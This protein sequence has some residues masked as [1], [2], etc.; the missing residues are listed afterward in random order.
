MLLVLVACSPFNADFDRAQPEDLSGL[1]LLYGLNGQM[2]PAFLAFAGRLYGEEEGCPQVTVR[3]DGFDLF[4]GCTGSAGD[5]YGAASVQNMLGDYDPT[6]PSS[7]EFD[8][9]GFLGD[10]PLLQ[11]YRV[12]GTLG[13]EFACEAPAS[14]YSFDLALS[15][16][17][18]GGVYVAEYS[19]LLE[20]FP[21]EGLIYRW[22]L[23]E[24]GLGE[25]P[26]VGR[27]A[28]G[29]S[30]EY[31]VEGSVIRP[32]GRLEF[33]GANTLELTWPLEGVGCGYASVSGYPSG[34]TCTESWTP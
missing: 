11:P 8:E 34:N 14:C 21:E 16:E 1:A 27:Y 30:I 23:E 22:T 25:W 9:F 17:G 26:E 6:R 2:D 13:M 33:E 28:V 3:D 29:G 24:G 31:L 5:W 18:D 15:Y 12:S 4:G 10:S 7:V 19:A 32:V 20:E